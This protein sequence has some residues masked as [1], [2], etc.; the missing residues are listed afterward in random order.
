MPSKDKWAHNKP[1]IDTEILVAHNRGRSWSANHGYRTSTNDMSKRQNIERNNYMI[2][3]YAGF[4][5]G[6]NA[7]SELGKTFTQITRTCYDKDTRANHTRFKSSGFYPDCEI[8][9]ST[10]PSFSRR[11]GKET[12]L[13]PHPAVHEAWDTTT[14]VSYPAPKAQD[15]ATART[16]IAEASIT[17][18]GMTRE[19]YRKST[20]ASGFNENALLQDGKSYAT[21]K[22]LHTD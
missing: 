5:P 14:R 7:N 21:A 8:F 9:D 19:G 17:F 11:Y 20:Y 16:K 6:N 18:D 15:K 22:C 2:P 3:K 4:I 13:P 1:K 12:R 10:R